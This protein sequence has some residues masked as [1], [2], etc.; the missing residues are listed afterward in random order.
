MT[1][2]EFEQFLIENRKKVERASEEFDK[3]SRAFDEKIRE[4]L[5]AL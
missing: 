3:H 5:A 4:I 2:R 1:K